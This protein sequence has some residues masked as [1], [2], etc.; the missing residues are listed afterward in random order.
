MEDTVETPRPSPKRKSDKINTMTKLPSATSTPAVSNGVAQLNGSANGLNSITPQKVS[1]RR[2]NPPRPHNIE[3]LVR[4]EKL[5]AEDATSTF[6]LEDLSDS[7]DVWIMDL[8]RLIDPQELYG[9]TIILGDKSKF[10]I[11]GERYCT[12]AHDK[13]DDVTCVLNVGKEVL[14]YKTINIKSTGSLTVRRKLP[15]AVK[16]Q[17]VPTDNSGVQVPDNLKRRHPLFGVMREHK[18]RMRKRS[19]RSSLNK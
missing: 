5:N 16:V 19:S 18:K 8:P 6:N 17:P 12:V 11:K 2:L 3:E 7:E 9:Q 15:A 1:S 10:K 4:V 13:K 14:Q